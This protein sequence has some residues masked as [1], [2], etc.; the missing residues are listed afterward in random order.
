VTALAAQTTGE[1]L[2]R[3]SAGPLKSSIADAQTIISQVA[4]PFQGTL[5]GAWS[6][7]CTGYQSSGSVSGSFTITVTNDGTL[8]GSFTGSDSGSIS[9]TTSAN[10]SFSAAGGTA[11]IA[12]WSGQLVGGARLSG[13]GS[14]SGSGCSGS[15]SG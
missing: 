8:N 2:T 13:N 6:G 3:A 5:A 4:N 12:T 10:G 7:T 11:D 9:G 14:W 15:W 1:L